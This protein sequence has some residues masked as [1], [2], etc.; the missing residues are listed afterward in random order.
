MLKF[1]GKF[2]EKMLDELE[3]GGSK[4]GFETF[5]VSLGVIAVS[6]ILI[7]NNLCRLTALFEKES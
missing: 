6:L 4:A 7:N 1:D 2:T 5:A 3:E